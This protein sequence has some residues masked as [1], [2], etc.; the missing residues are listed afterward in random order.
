MK[1]LIVIFFISALLPLKMNCQ[2]SISYV[3]QAQPKGMFKLMPGSHAKTTV[4]Y[5]DGKLRYTTDALGYEQ[6]YIIDKDSVK[7]ESNYTG[8]DYCGQGTIEEY[9]NDYNKDLPGKAVYGD[10]SMEKTSETKMIFKYN[11]NRVIIKYTT[12]KLNGEKRENEYYGWYTSEIKAEPIYKLLAV[13]F[14]EN[15]EYWNAFVELEG[16]IIETE[17]YNGDKLAFVT[18]TQNLNFKNVKPEDLNFQLTCRKKKTMKKLSDDMN[19]IRN[20]RY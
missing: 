8:K 1:S 19:G 4:F 2:T 14:P 16:F 18:Q 17:S 7:L 9:H 3:Q 12:L 10:V 6:T 5:Q 13:L 15:A 20:R 11:C